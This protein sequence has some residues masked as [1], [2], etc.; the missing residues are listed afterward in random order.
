MPEENN[1]Y[2]E[3]PSVNNKAS[4]KID[5]DQYLSDATPHVFFLLTLSNKVWYKSIKIK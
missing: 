3:P 4:R 1:V 5:M 2:P